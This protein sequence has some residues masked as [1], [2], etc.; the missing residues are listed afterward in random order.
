MN[1]PGNEAEELEIE[2]TDGTGTVEEGVVEPELNEDGTTKEPEVEAW[3]QE[4]DQT[5]AE[6]SE[7]EKPKKLN[8][9]QK[10]RGEVKE[11]NL[12]NERLQAEIDA[13]K[14]GQAPAAVTVAKRPRLND[15]D[16]DE[17]YEDAMDKWEEEK[18]TATF[19]T[20]ETKRDVTARQQ[21]HRQV[22]TD[23]VDAHYERAQELVTKHSI[24]PE[25]YQKADA[26]VRQS[27]EAVA[28]GQGEVI[29]N[30]LISL[31]G[32]GSEKVMYHLG[33]NKAALNELRA[34]LQDDPSGLKA[35]AFIGQKKAEITGP[36]HK[37]TSAPKPVAQINGETVAKPS[38]SKKAYD[39]AHKE[40]RGQD[41]FDIKGEARKAGVDTSSW[42]S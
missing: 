3:M 31:V 18:T 15:F 13:L 19:Q 10:L 36:K 25:V 2:G 20:L 34:I 32:K 41:A 37:L 8:T 22:L 24:N 28:P 14:R 11:A 1:T 7:G 16:S 4:E 23:A 26:T 38:A 29:V 27:I 12:E 39:K 40:G 17:L 5:A 30:Q 21:Q 9:K 33:V 42:V 35:A 6:E